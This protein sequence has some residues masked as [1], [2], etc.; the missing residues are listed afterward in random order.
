MIKLSAKQKEKI[1]GFSEEFRQ[2]YLESDK[3][4]DHIQRYLIK[5]QEKAIA[6]EKVQKE[7]EKD[8][9]RLRD[10]MLHKAFRGRL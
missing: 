7:T 4:R 8:V 6:L 3:G 1:K 5:I 2:K 10:A 9:E